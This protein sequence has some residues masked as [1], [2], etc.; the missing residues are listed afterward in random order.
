MAAL[1][2]V[3]HAGYLPRCESLDRTVDDAVARGQIAPSTRSEPAVAPLA[4][5]SDRRPLR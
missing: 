5:G 4:A 3:G 2:G 1:T